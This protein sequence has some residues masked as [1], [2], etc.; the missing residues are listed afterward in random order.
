MSSDTITLIGDSVLDNFY[1]LENND[2]TEQLKEIG[3]NVNNFAVDE[4]RLTDI[5]NGV[6]PRSFYK[7]KRHYP[8]PTDENGKV[9]PLNLLTK[10][11]KQTVVIS[12]GGN[13]MRENLLKFLFQGPVSGFKS[14][15]N[16][17]YI[18]DFEQLLI[19]IRNYCSKIILVC[20][21]APYIGNGSNYVMF[22]SLKDTVYTQLINM[23][24]SIG[25]KLNIPVLD[26]S[27]TFDCYNRSHY[28]STEIEPSN[29][30]SKCIAD[31]IDYI[32]KHY[33]GYNVYY[34][35]NCNINQ[36]K[37]DF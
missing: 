31:S 29:F 13:D 33:Q 9:V 26:L 19:N 23:Y 14:I 7:S 4:S 21:Y 35:P 18:E 24:K 22:S 30:S 2:L 12:V 16:D 37:C 27:R 8:Y 20:V 1:W 32:H 5:I 34:S 6:V 28:G 11:T 36:I 17:K 25:S 3:Y 15:F 10:D